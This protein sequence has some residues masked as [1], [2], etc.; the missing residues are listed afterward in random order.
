MV[1]A[2]DVSGEDEDG[3]QQN[4]KFPAIESKMEEPPSTRRFSFSTT[5]TTFPSCTTARWCRRKDEGVE[6]RYNFSCFSFATMLRV[7]EG[8]RQDLQRLGTAW[9]AVEGSK[10]MHIREDG[11]SE[12]Y[13][14][15][16]LW[17]G[18]S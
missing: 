16:I 18:I 7:T 6:M 12:G 4:T 1:E 17:G 5:A 11:N 2:K 14:D 3:G 8:M 9:I 10:R 13:I 15:Q